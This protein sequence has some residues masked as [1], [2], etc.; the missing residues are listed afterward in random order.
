M[1]ARILLA[2]PLV[3]IACGSDAPDVDSGRRDDRDP[4]AELV[5]YCDRQ[6]TSEMDCS[7]R[8]PEGGGFYCECVGIER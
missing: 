3:L 2:I 1:S 6:D 8:W 4:F 5:A 7:A